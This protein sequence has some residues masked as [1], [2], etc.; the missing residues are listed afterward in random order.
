[1]KSR[2]P[3]RSLFKIIIYGKSSMRLFIAAIISLGFSISVI[4]ATMGLMDGF[5]LS[6]KK[7]LRKSN[8]DLRIT[9]REGFFKQE[10]VEKVLNKNGF[11]RTVG[12]NQIEA[13]FMFNGNSKGIVLS[14]VDTKKYEEVTNVNLKIS[15]NGTCIGKELAKD[16]GI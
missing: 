1:M 16:L 7:G 9:S 10:D 8:G 3:F 12:I 11:T 15:K 14:A 5:S 13:F 6:L 2:A 4:L